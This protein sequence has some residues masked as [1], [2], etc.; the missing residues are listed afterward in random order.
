[1]ASIDG[2]QP[3]NPD[4]LGD[5]LVRVVGMATPPRIFVAGSDALEL[6]APSIDMRL[7]DMQAFADLSKSTDGQF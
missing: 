5:I 7:H 1:M 6:I 2:N 3:G 4:K